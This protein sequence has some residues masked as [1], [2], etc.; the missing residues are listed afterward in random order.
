MALQSQKVYLRVV[1]CNIGR[2]ER[3]SM[4]CNYLVGGQAVLAVILIPT[5]KGSCS[6]D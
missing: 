4:L 5:V 1:I 6:L 3:F 2:E